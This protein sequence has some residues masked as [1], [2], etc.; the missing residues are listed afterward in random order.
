MCTFFY[1]LKYQR[2]Q[3]TESQNKHC[4]NLKRNWL[5]SIISDVAR[6]FFSCVLRSV[7]TRREE[8]KREV[9]L[10]MK[11]TVK[12]C[13]IFFQNR[14]K[15]DTYFLAK[16]EQ[17]ITKFS[18]AEGR[19]SHTWNRYQQ[20]EPGQSVCRLPVRPARSFEYSNQ[21]KNQ[22]CLCIDNARLCLFNWLWK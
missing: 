3:E 14:R 19:Y 6:I 22:T 21:F 8:N 1:W 12:K 13:Y 17:A 10:K 11:G 16:S 15:F 18:K 7:A 20:T 2:E 4:S 9:F 5:N